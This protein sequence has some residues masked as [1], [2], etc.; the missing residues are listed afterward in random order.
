MAIA[1]GAAAV[2]IPGALAPALIGAGVGAGIGKLARAN[3]EKVQTNTDEM[4][5]LMSSGKV[6][7]EETM[8]AELEKMGYF[9]DAAQQ[10]AEEL[11]N[12]S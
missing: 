4:A 12:N 8:L 10:M 2:L 9:G 3:N 6:H 1:S 11:L 7:D 5:K